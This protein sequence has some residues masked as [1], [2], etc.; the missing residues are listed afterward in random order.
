MF[1]TILYVLILISFHLIPFTEVVPLMV[2]LSHKHRTLFYSMRMKACAYEA[3][4]HGV[5]SNGIS[6]L[7]SIFKVKRHMR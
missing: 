3:R 4:R 7:R 5:V 1:R 6:F 2:R